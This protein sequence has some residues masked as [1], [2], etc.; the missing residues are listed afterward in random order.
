MPG[1]PT[2]KIPN[3]VLAMSL[4]R[5]RENANTIVRIRNWRIRAKDLMY[6]LYMEFC[7]LGDSFNLQ[8]LYVNGRNLWDDSTPSWMPEPF[9]W[10][11][12]E[13]LATAGALMEQ[14]EMKRDPLTSWTPIIHRDTK[15]ENVF[16]GA[17]SDSRYV[18]YPGVKLADFGFAVFSKAGDRRNPT[19]IAVRGTRNCR[20]PEQVH[21]VL[22]EEKGVRRLS[23]KTNVWGIG[24]IMW[25]YIMIFGFT[26]CAP[27]NFDD[28]RRCE[29]AFYD[30][31]AEYR[32][33]QVYS[34][35]LLRLILQ[36]MKYKPEERPTFTRIL[37]R[38][39]HFTS[40]GPVDHARG[41]RKAAQDDK[42]WQDHALAGGLYDRFPVKSLLWD[43]DDPPAGLERFPSP[44]AE[45]ED[46][47]DDELGGLA[48]AEIEGPRRL[49]RGSGSGARTPR[50]D[51][52]D[53]PGDDELDDE[54]DDE[55]GG[56]RSSHEERRSSGRGSQADG[57]TERTTVGSKRKG[58][59]E[60]HGSDTVESQY[61]PRKRRA[62]GG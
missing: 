3:E 6:R 35:D 24:M 41:L 57:G 26:R 62:R 48:G 7:P 42:A 37:K 25:S 61:G 9:L 10:H 56:D 31:G 50:S 55:P 30:D 60:G 53:E 12:F 2:D 36:C 54:P 45:S 16:L 27:L 19:E 34:A 5:S 14:G 43:I 8:A 32:P 47:S 40:G 33:E 11:A 17:S 44:P 52:D 29:P 38:I 21:H 4:L 23:E 28:E 46:S 13:Y 58:S 22:R 49:D 51:D 20:A 59:G 18:G 39:R 15:A 1:R